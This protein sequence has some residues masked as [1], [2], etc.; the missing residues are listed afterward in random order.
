MLDVGCGWGDFSNKLSPFL[1]TYVG[2]EPS[3]IEL[4]RFTK[5]PNRFLV[6]GVGEYLD[7]LK[8]HSRNFILLNSVLDHCY[9]WKRACANCLRV[10]APGGLLIIS[11]ENSQKLTI[12]L[13]KALGQKYVH[14]GHLEFFGLDDTKKILPP[15]FQ[16]L[17]DRTIGFFFGLHAFTKRVPLPVAPLRLA[18]RAANAFFRV[19]APKGGHIF[20][21]S[22]VRQGTPPGP[23]SYASPFRC[24]QCA[25]DLPFGACTCKNC[26]QVFSY[27]DAGYL[28]SAELNPSLKLEL[29]GK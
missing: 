4:R 23:D 25:A 6:R 22:A 18:N 17:E 2:V 27:G 14:E 7:F 5:R 15:D 16:I 10:L 8:D 24:P 11:M 29:G 3:P 19:V 13:R 21:L 26:G 20:F 1:K 12:R 28:D 9:D